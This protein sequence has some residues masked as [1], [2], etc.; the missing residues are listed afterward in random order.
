MTAG[1]Y[2]QDTMTALQRHL[3]LPQEIQTAQK[4]IAR[5]SMG[6]SYV[7]QGLRLKSLIDDI[8][9]SNIIEDKLYKM[10]GWFTTF[11]SCISGLLGIFFIWRAISI[12]IKTSINVTILYQ[13]FGWSIKLIAG[14]F[15]IEK[16]QGCELEHTNKRPLK[17]EKRNEIERQLLKDLASKWRRNYVSDMEFGRI[18]PPN[19]YGLPVLRKAKQEYKD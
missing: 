18:S 3:L 2:S 1:I 7:D 6:Y 13:T 12:L 9:I 16:F 19:L 4:N 10:W 15:S 17:S 8:T 5:Q 14:I 11:G